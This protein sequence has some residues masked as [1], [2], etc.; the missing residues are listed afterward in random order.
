M[1]DRADKLKKMGPAKEI[2]HDAGILSM[3]DHGDWVGQISVRKREH[4]AV[5]EMATTVGE[6]DEILSILSPRDCRSFCYNVSVTPE[7]LFPHRARDAFTQ[8]IVDKF[9]R[10]NLIT[11]GAQLGLYLLCILRCFGQSAPAS[12]MEKAHADSRS[13][14]PSIRFLASS[15]R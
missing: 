7:N 14:S 3:D 15:P 13:H 10:L 5:V 1:H 11:G 4:E 9:R 8:D 12:S 2:G 6:I